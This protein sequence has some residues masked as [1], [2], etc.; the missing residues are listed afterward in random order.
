M[1]GNSAQIKDRIVMSALACFSEHGVG[2][3]KLGQIA[4][5][6][7][8]DQPL[9]NYHF[10][11]FEDLLSA[12]VEVTEKDLIATSVKAIES[13]KNTPTAQLEA[14]IRAPLLWA[15]KKPDYFTFWM[16]FYHLA[17][18]NPRFA[19]INEAGADG[20]RE[21]IRMMI[22]HGLE[23]GVFHLPKNKK[24]IDVAAEIQ[25]IITGFTI[26]AGVEHQRKISYWSDLA[27]HSCFVLLGLAT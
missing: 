4:K 24:A 10:S 13:A 3:T 11:S 22:Y 6:A 25:G 21:R 7:K 26:M 9:L 16:Y 14:Y 20:G 12:V 18:H 8:V 15:Q 19:Q 5:H 27:V 1:A 23:D 17:T 2:S